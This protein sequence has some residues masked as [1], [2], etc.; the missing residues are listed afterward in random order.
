VGAVVVVVSHDVE[1]FTSRASRA[2]TLREGR[3]VEVALPEGPA[4]R[5]EILDLMARG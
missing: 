1:P 4:E 5:L 3:C 2:F